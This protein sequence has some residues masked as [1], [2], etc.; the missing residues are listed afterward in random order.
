M[1]SKCANPA[2]PNVFRRLSE[3]KLFQVETECLEMS[4]PYR[5]GFAR[6]KNGRR[7]EHFWLC[8]ECSSYLTLAFERGQGMT[9]VP[10]PAGGA[11][12]SVA[13]VGLGEIR[14]SSQPSYGNGN[15]NAG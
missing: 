11:R 6:H 1:L 10:L 3:G 4:N 8:D 15:R 14:P 12:K 5:A 9:T 2:C 7:V 13:A